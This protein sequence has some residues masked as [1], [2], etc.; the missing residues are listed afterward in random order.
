MLKCFPQANE[1]SDYR[2]AIYIISLPE[3]FRKI[4]GKEGRYPF[5]W[6]NAVE[7]V[8]TIGFDEVSD[9]TY[10]FYDLRILREKED[11][12]ADYS[13]AYYTL[14][15]SNQSLV[16]LGEELFGNVYKGFEIMDAIAD[17]DNNLYKVFMQVLK[18][19]RS[20]HGV[21]GLKILIE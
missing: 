6:V 9:E 15:S 4:G 10:S 16:Q 7:E 14:S 19:R 17:F 20:K 2:C 12:S 21:R 11:G 8:E 3:I 1:Y 13:D 18:M 5:V